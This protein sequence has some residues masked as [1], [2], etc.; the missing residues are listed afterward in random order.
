MKD[1]EKPESVSDFKKLVWGAYYKNTQCLGLKVNGYSDLILFI[2]CHNSCFAS[3]FFIN[4]FLSFNKC[5][6]LY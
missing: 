1:A 2:L 6:L 3:S 5:I 4:I